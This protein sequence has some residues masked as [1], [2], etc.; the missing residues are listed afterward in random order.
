VFDEERFDGEYQVGEDGAIDFPMVGSLAV[1][2]LDKDAV[3]HLIEEKLADGY[4]NN[5]HV[6]VQ[7]KQRG[8]REVSVLGQVNKAGSLDYR[9]GLT[10]VQAVSEAGGLTDF[11]APKRVK[12]T[13]RT[14]NGDETITF[15]VSLSAIIEGRA[16]DLVLRPGDIVFVPETWI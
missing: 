6:T 10:I 8:N 15:E 2:G 11:A 14:G 7:V 13:R 5:P 9:D 1:R 3:A 16:E 4:L 12:L